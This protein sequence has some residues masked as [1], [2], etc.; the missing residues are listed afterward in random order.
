M[1]IR[2]S[3]AEEPSFTLA[4][5]RLIENDW[6]HPY[7]LSRTNLKV[8]LERNSPSITYYAIW[9]KSDLNANPIYSGDVSH[10]KTQ[11]GKKFIQIGCKRFVGENRRKLIAWAKNG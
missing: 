1:I 6:W 11:R 2:T 7:A 9:N 4:P 5:D 8:A 10:G 3:K